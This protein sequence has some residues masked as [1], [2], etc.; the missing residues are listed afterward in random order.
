LIFIDYARCCLITVAGF[1]IFLNAHN[2]RITFTQ[3]GCLGIG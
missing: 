1:F 3:V 2:K